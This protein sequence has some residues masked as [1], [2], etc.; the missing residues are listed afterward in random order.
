MTCSEQKKHTQMVQQFQGLDPWITLETWNVRQKIHPIF[1]SFQA[2]MVCLA[3][4]SH[5]LWFEVTIYLKTPREMYRSKN[6]N[7]FELSCLEFEH[8]LS[9]WLLYNSNF[10]TLTCSLICHFHHHWLPSWKIFW[11]SNDACELS[12]FVRGRAWRIVSGEHGVLMLVIWE[13]RNRSDQNKMT[14]LGKSREIWD[15]NLTLSWQFPGIL[16]KIEARKP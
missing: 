6:I 1:I 10:L 15:A 11:N 3:F 13:S 4:S 12:C 14:W 7:W 8:I 5:R 2:S 16:G 9:E